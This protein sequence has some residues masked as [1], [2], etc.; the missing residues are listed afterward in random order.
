M[1]LFDIAHHYGLRFSHCRLGGGMCLVMSVS[2][3]DRHTVDNVPVCQ[4]VLL[5]HKT[6]EKNQILYKSSSD[7]FSHVFHAP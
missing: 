4:P 7:A 3:A 5:S 1:A 6:R 2:H